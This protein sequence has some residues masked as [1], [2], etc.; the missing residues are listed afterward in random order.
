[1]VACCLS[2]APVTTRTFRS[3]L[4]ILG[5]FF[6]VEMVN[7]ADLLDGSGKFDS[8]ED[9]DKWTIKT[10]DS[11]NVSVETVAASGGPYLQLNKK[12]G[13]ND[14]MNDGLFYQFTP[15]Q[16]R[17]VTFAFQTS[18][19]NLE[20]VNIRLR[21]SKDSASDDE[22]RDIMFFR[23]GRLSYA[24]F[25]EHQMAGKYKTNQ[26]HQVDLVM[27]WKIEEKYINF[28]LDGELQGTSQ[29]YFFE[30][31][32]SKLKHANQIFLYNFSNNTE[33]KLKNMEVC[34]DYCNLQ[35]SLKYSSSTRLL[36]DCSLP[37]MITVLF[38]FIA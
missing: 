20:D 27:N 6:L 24:R 4:V 9:L 29:P 18:D 14:E 16:I 7:A 2:S 28:Y 17:H 37:L 23:C 3:Q 21:Q 31:D 8:V 33:V 11:Y 25:N 13:S 30:K 32:Y 12:A 26:W 36:L 35:A 1:M 19:D 10:P 22:D 15:K 38:W 5:L 34:D